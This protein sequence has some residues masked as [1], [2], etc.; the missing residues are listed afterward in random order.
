MSPQACAAQS[1]GRAPSAWNAQAMA[2]PITRS[3]DKPPNFSRPPL[4]LKPMVADLRP[5]AFAFVM[6]TGIVAHDARLAAMSMVGQ[7]LLSIALVSYVGLFVLTVTRL[8]RFPERVVNELGSP[9]R[10]P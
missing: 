4:C 8:I 5:G 1:G 10:G 3:L 7:V 2:P 9:K 6:A